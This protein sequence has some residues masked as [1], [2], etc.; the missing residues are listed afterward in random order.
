MHGMKTSTLIGA[1]LSGLTAFICLLL[2]LGLSR[3][4]FILSFFS[5]MENVMTIIN[6]VG[7][8]LLLISVIM[9]VLTIVLCLKIK[10]EKAD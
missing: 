8:V 5:E 2:G 1:I 10:K 7:I 4:G 3:M 6:L 9:L